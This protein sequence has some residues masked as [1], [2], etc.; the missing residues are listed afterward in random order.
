MLQETS[1]QNV[2]LQKRSVKKK[3]LKKDLKKEDKV[4]KQRRKTSIGGFSLY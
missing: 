3:H 1:E 4:L 2:L